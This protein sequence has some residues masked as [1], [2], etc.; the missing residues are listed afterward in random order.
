MTPE[1]HQQI[2]QLL[3]EL[4]EFRRTSNACFKWLGSAV[5]VLFMYVAFYVALS[6]WTT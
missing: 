2:V 6:L 4:V 1:Q 3:T 5:A